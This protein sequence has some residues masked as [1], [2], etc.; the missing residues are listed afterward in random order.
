MVDGDEAQELRMLFY[1]VKQMVK[2]MRDGV[3]SVL[4]DS[5]QIKNKPELFKFYPGFLF[6]FTIM[7]THHLPMNL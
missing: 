6:C 4:N 5:S 2:G 7:D 3:F 1:Q